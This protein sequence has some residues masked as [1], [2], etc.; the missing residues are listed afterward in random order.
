LT[1][2]CCFTDFAAMAKRRKLLEPVPGNVQ[3]ALRKMLD[4]HGQ[5]RTC[6]FLHLSPTSL[7]RALA[8]MDVRRATVG[9]MRRV[10]EAFGL[11]EKE[12]PVASE[13]PSRERA[14]GAFL[15]QCCAQSPAHGVEASVLYSAWVSWCEDRDLVPSTLAVFARDMLAVCKGVVVT[16]P[17]EGTKRPRMYEGIHLKP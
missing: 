15:A 10:L 7:M 12:P 9:Q 5:S 11:L 14:L 6:H 13:M 2:T 1:S 16:R 8:G 4:E 17:R 3:A